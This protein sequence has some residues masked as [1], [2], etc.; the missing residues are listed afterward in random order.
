MF[1]TKSTVQSAEIQV[2]AKKLATHRSCLLL[3]VLFGQIAKFFCAD[4]QAE[5]NLDFYG[6]RRQLN[7]L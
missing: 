1:V 5:F 3:N 6:K 4:V 2:C 7:G